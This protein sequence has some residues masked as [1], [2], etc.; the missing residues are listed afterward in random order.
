[1]TT[2]PQA[3]EDAQPA[4]SKTGAV[5]SA[6]AEPG[7]EPE[8]PEFQL[9][10]QPEE[11]TGR[12]ASFDARVEKLRREYFGTSG[13]FLPGLDNL[14]HRRLGLAPMST[15]GTLL[16]G[17]I[18]A[19]V[20]LLIAL[21]A[22]LVVGQWAGIPWDRWAIVIAAYFALEAENAWSVP[23]PGVEPPE[24]YKRFMFDWTALLPTIERESDVRELA[25]F[26]RRWLRQP[27]MV[28]AG[29]AV[30]AIM[31]LACLLFSPDALVELPAGSIVL[32]AWLL[33]DFGMAPIY[34]GNLFN[35]AFTAR[36]ARYDHHLFW[37][38]PADSPEVQKVMRKTTVQGIAAGLYTTIFL[39]LTVVLVGWDSPLVL[40][41][42]VGFVVIGYLT[43]I[44]L[45]VGNRASVRRIIER[46]RQQRLALFRSRID[47]FEPR[48]VDLSPE[49][50]EQLRNLLFLHD[51]IRDA[52]SSPSTA[53]TALRTAAGL[54][55]PTIAFVITVFGEVS[56]ERLLD[57]LLP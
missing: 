19:G 24:R 8:P 7:T 20:R 43:T 53:Q 25:D 6:A 41:L 18:G 31:L 55:I 44:G 48:M 35:R 28:A 52:S 45:A 50:S 10:P 3:P 23:P 1:M 34:W 12:S 39:V 13:G 27:V 14:V 33:V 49:E 47:A 30:A 46:S 40:P 37:P 57:A 5:E 56:A 42:A 17:L 9:E 22:T 11:P 32:V 15:G 21:L 16:S 36:E 38:S 29:A 2:T 4:R 51:K 26:T 54:L